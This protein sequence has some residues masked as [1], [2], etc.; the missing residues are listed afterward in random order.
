ML[1]SEDRAEIYALETQKM[2]EVGMYFFTFCLYECRANIETLR[3]T[4][5]SGNKVNV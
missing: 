4:C 5:V 3:L 1:D 2:V